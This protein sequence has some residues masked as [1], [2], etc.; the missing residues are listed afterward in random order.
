[1]EKDDESEDEETHEVIMETRGRKKMPKR[2]LAVSVRETEKIDVEKSER[3][4]RKA[5]RKHNKKKEAPG[6][7]DEHLADDILNITDQEQ[8]F[9]QESENEEERER[10]DD[11]EQGKQEEERVLYHDG[12]QGSTNKSHR[13][14][15]SNK[16]GERRSGAGIVSKSMATS[17]ILKK[18]ISTR[19]LLL[20]ALKRKRESDEEGNKQTR[21]SLRKMTELLTTLVGNTSQRQSTDSID[22]GW[23]IGHST[24][25]SQN[26]VESQ[27]NEGNLMRALQSTVNAIS[28]PQQAGF[29]SECVPSSGNE[30][31]LTDWQF[32]REKFEANMAIKGITDPLLMEQQFTAVAGMKLRTVLRTAPNYENAEETGYNLIVRKLDGVFLGR[33]GS[34]T[35]MQMLRNIKQ[36][37]DESNFAFLGRLKMAAMR[38]FPFEG[39]EMYREMSHCVVSG[40]TSERLRSYLMLPASGDSEGKP[41]PYE[42]V[43]NYAQGLDNLEMSK[44]TKHLN[45]VESKEEERSHRRSKESSSYSARG[46][47]RQS[48]GFKPMMSQDR[49]QNVCKSCGNFN[50]DVRDCPFRTTICYNCGLRGHLARV[51]RKPKGGSTRGSGSQKKE[52]AIESEAKAETI[53][54]VI[55]DA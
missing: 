10:D 4:V 43:V 28:I 51:C 48:Q 19:K 39:E 20:K 34:F 31:Q 21:E 37:R 42:S 38:V 50:H 12:L 47:F 2:R 33:A 46:G 44:S 5:A 41:K 36:K 30:I 40:T 24:P 26:Q 53:K 1:M 22:T 27:N 55:N 45:M 14:N 3:S 11:M 7:S 18:R 13:A 29:V 16:A 54:E 9:R 32:W 25:L 49:N 8:L 6:F 17:K 23:M 35:R 52:E 15:R